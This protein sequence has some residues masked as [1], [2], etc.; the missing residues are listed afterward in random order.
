MTPK[1][2]RAIFFHGTKKQTSAL[3][4]F[5][6]RKT[7]FFLPSRAAPPLPNKNSP[8]RKDAAPGDGVAA[9]L[10]D[11]AALFERSECERRALD[12]LP[13]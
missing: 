6:I 1:S 7:A 10:H 11:E 8:R 9:L 4:S 2:C 5:R 12:R 13:A 3:S